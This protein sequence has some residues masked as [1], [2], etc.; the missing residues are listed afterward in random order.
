MRDISANVDSIPNIFR[1]KC[2]RGIDT[3]N[4]PSGTTPLAPQTKWRRFHSI[5][6][7]FLAGRWSIS[8]FRVY[9]VTLMRDISVNVDSIPN[10]FR[11]KCDRGIDT[12]NG[13]SGTPP[14]APRTKWRRFHS[15]GGGLHGNRS[16]A[17]FL[18]LRSNFNA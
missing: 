14:I 13:P 5:G 8:D 1:G 4:G 10:I 15:I 2:Y 18:N 3:S 11:G 6:A 7:V 17:H 16:L 9:G 12:S